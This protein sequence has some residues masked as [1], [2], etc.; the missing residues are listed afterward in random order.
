ML[1]FK[2]PSSIISRLSSLTNPV[3][4]GAQRRETFRLTRCVASKS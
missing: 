2:L 1:D 3:A 4:L